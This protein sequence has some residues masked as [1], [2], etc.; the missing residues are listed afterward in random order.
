MNDISLEELEK[1]L[2]LDKTSKSREDSMYDAEI[3]SS[4]ENGRL[5]EESR[6]D[7]EGNEQKEE[8]KRE[9]ISLNLKIKAKK[10][11]MM[12]PWMLNAIQLA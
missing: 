7:A 9:I 8:I 5:S 11:R 2:K 4:N 1:Y 12:K 3:D 10:R 6:K